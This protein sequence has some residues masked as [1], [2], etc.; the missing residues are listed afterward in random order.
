MP[1]LYELRAVCDKDVLPTKEDAIRYRKMV[2]NNV[3]Y[4]AWLLQVPARKR[5]QMF[6]GFFKT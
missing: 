6:K 2:K 1:E 3:N 5:K 4:F